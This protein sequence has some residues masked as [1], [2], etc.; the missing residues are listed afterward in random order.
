MQGTDMNT[1]MQ[2]KNAENWNQT[3]EDWQF[4]MRSGSELCLVAVLKNR[5]IGTVTAINYQNRLAWIGMM[6]VSKNHRGMGVGKLLLN[7]IIEK[8]K[9]CVS[10][11]LD[12]T[13]AGIPVYKKLGFIKEFTIDRMVSK[14]PR[15]IDTDQHR[16]TPMGVSRILESDITHIA[17]IDKTLFGADRSDLFRFLYD[18]HKNIGLQL[19]KNK[20]LKGYL[21]GRKGSD[22]VQVGP[23]MADST[24]VARKLLCEVFQK[25]KGQSVVVDV[26]GDKTDLKNWLFSIGFSGQRSFTRM[27]LK[28]NKFSGKSE[29]QFLICGPELG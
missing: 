29:N 12:A 16:E 3:V 19:K 2:I 22:F 28:S 13:P 25:L 20:Q 27:V 11:K 5:V 24:L 17:N 21:F 4:L 15:T 1:V 8:L 7:T 18:S 14:E 26:L 6:L 9:D 10:I 23:V